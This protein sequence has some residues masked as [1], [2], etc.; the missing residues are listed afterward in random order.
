MIIPRRAFPPGFAEWLQ[1]LLNAR[2]AFLLRMSLVERGIG[3]EIIE[4]FRRFGR[5]PTESEIAQGV[6]MP[7]H[8]VVKRLEVLSA[9]DFLKYDSQSGRILALYPFS[10]VPCPH[11]VTL[12]GKA[13]LYG[14]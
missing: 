14:M 10:D 1:P 2:R 12:L 8:D 13:P 4:R 5:G 11:R 6:G 9:K 7:E 3:T